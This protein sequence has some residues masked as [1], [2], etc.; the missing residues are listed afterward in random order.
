MLISCEKHLFVVFYQLLFASLFIAAWLP[1]PG[2]QPGCH[3]AILLG[4]LPGWLPGCL[5]GYLPGSLP[6]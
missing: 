3:S 2:W 4:W 6:G 1:G 5:A